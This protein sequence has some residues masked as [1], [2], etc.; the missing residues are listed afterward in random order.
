MPPVRG[1]TA[2]VRRRLGRVRGR[3]VQ[4]HGAQGRVV[5][6]RQVRGGRGAP[7]RRR[8]A[9]TLTGLTLQVAVLRRRVLTTARLRVPCRP[10]GCVMGVGP[11]NA[12]GAVFDAR[13]ADGVILRGVG[14]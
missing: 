10:M 14:C 1:Q 6:T 11:N 4:E 12:S 5:R 13:Y 8:R 9:S 7:R 3:E 2:Q